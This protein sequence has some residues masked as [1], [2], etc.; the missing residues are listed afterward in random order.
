MVY[1]GEDHSGDDFS[2]GPLLMKLAVEVE[3]L[4]V[5]ANIGEGG[6]NNAFAACPIVQYTVNGAVH[7]VYKR[8]SPIPYGFSAWSVFTYTWASASNMLHTDFEIYDN[9]TDMLTGGGVWTYCDYNTN[10]VGYPRY[11]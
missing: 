11:A 5:S 1:I 10:D 8:T 4:T 2:S 3:D 7:S 6:F 9:M